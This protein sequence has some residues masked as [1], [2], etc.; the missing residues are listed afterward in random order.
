MSTQKS[1][2]NITIQT[3]VEIARICDKNLIDVV[4]AD[5]LRSGGL[6]KWHVP[7]NQTDLG[8]DN[9]DENQLVWDLGD[10]ISK[11]SFSSKYKFMLVFAYMLCGGSVI[12]ENQH[13]TSFNIAIFNKY[14]ASSELLSLE[15]CLQIAKALLSYQKEPKEIFPEIKEN[16]Q[17]V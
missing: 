4:M 2:M 1:I 5:F 14:I 8:G 12:L 11:D 6:L 10:Y 17:Q 13:F 9:A 16:S 3:L 15:D 7:Q